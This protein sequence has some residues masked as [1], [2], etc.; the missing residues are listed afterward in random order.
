MATSITEI[1]GMLEELEVNYKDVIENAVLY[2]YKTKNY[3]DKD[4]DYALMIVI[5]LTENGEYIK[6]F[7]QRRLWPMALM[8]P[9]CCRLAWK[10]NGKQN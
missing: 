4:G 7:S 2:Y 3:I 1:K 6:F 5:E 10:C 8:F 9:P